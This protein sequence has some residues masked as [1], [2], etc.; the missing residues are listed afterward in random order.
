MGQRLMSTKD[1]EDRHPRQSIPPLS[2]FPGD[3]ECIVV[4]PVPICL[5]KC[6]RPGEHD[7]IRINRIR[8][9]RV[10]IMNWNRTFG[11]HNNVRRWI[12]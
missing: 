6:M 10:E 9:Q 12:E 7:R 8:S 4:R 5:P 2:V 11:K 3:I 1:W